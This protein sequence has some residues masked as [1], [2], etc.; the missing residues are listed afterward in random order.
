M[1]EKRN[2]I[3]RGV[4]GTWLV[5]SYG[6][7]ANAP[8][9]VATLYFVG[10][11][12]LAGGALPLITLLSYIIYATTLVIIYEWSKD[13]ASAY[14][15]VAIV[16]KGLGSSLAS[17]TVGYGY[18]YQYLVS[19][20]AGFGILGIA[21]FLYLINPSIQSTMPWL[22]AVI[23]T[24]ITI[25]VTLLMWFGVKPGGMLNLIVGLVSIGFL[26]ITSLIL[27]GLAGSNNTLSVFTPQP[28]G[29][30]W[31][32]VLTAMIFGITTFGGAT[33]PIGV[34]EEAKIPKKTLPKA[35]L[36]GFAVLGIGLLLNAYAQT[37][38]YGPSN[39]FNYATLSDPM[40][41]IYSKYFNPVIVIL[42]I[43]LVAFMFNSSTLAFATSGSRMVYG[44]ARDNVLYPSI[45]SKV[46]KH[47]VPGNAIILTGAII[48]A[49]SLISGYILGPLE[50]SIFLIT[51]GSFYVAFGHL[52]AAIG[53][54]RYKVKIK[55]ANLVKHI[56]IPVISA[57]AYI[58]VIYFGTYPAPAFPL[59]I[60]VFLAWGVL[61]LHA[62]GY[63]I[64]KTRKP[65]IMKKF[66]DFSI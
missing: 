10:I 8:I 26:I 52:F 9:A 51:F 46:N 40:I 25:E 31:I 35:L 2:E 5:A 4:L 34:A 44:M 41:I 50:A 6:I 43:I 61:G 20:A 60:A 1:D 55:M 28:I 19:G 62:V 30:N 11:A 27:I 66:G 18:L 23:V 32:L 53:L 7:A 17:F 21:S 16:K 12:G 54:V 14:S 59:N 24:I 15:F 65:E 36:L 38:I 49:L 29:N 37:V 22:W 42:L 58:M 3:R 47:G 45:F 64:L 56:I 13:I 48:G 63:Y 39:M 33:T 57:I